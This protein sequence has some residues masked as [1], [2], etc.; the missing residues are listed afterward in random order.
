MK[1]VILN[2]LVLFVFTSG[3]SQDLFFDIRGTD[4]RPVDQDV[5]VSANSLKDINPGFPDSWITFYVSTEIE[6]TANGKTSKAIGS[7]GQL[8]DA[9]KDLLKNAD[10][11]SNIDVNV[12]YYEV[13]A[14]TNISELSN[15]NFTLSLAPAKAAEY[16]GGYDPMTDY[17]EEN[18]MNMINLMNAGNFSMA[19]VKFTI[20]KDGLVK[21]ARVSQTSDN[22]V[23]DQTM[24]K[25]I[26]N[27][28]K[29]KP[30][31]DANGDK[32]DQEFQF[33]VGNGC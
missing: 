29:W 13:N 18:A 32:I 28:P 7:N 25:A 20:D 9:Q 11:G 22:A 2:L 5:L 26:K 24:L 27:M 33:M 15:M 31:M 3:F 10:I 21:K 14:Q 4:G 8:S 6:A 16:Q 30:A 23:I 17:L 1:K 19:T 12:A